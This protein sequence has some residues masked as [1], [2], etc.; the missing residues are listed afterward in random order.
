MWILGGKGEQFN[1]FGEQHFHRQHKVSNLKD[2]SIL[3][4]NNGNILPVAP[5]PVIAEDDLI[6]EKKAETSISFS[7]SVLGKLGNLG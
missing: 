6:K 7:F 5:Y 2:G 1:L 3:I 4:F